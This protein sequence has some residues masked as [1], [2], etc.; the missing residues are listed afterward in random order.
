MVFQSINSPVLFVV[1]GLTCTGKTTIAARLNSWFGMPSVSK[2]YYKELLFD[3]LGWSDREWSK[4]LDIPSLELLY[5]FTEKMLLAMYPCLIESTFS[6]DIE[7][8]SH[9]IKEYNPQV[10]QIFCVA[11]RRILIERFESRSLTPH[12]H[13]GHVDNLT[14]DEHR[15]ILLEEESSPLKLDSDTIEIDTTIFEKIN[16]EAIKND[17]SILLKSRK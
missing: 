15:K 1:N 17:I 11:D 16:F 9:I 8:L 14:W 2:D 12:R 3:T 13:P 5:Q 10:I 7:R 6:N 4:K